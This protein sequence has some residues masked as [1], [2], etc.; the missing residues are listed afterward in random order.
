MPDLQDRLYLE[1]VAGIGH[2]AI[3]LRNEVPSVLRKAGVTPHGNRRR[4]SVPGRREQKVP[5][6]CDARAPGCGRYDLTDHA[7]FLD[8]RAQA[9][10]R[11]VHMAQF[12]LF[13]GGI[14]LT[15]VQLYDIAV[16]SVLGHGA[17]GA[18]IEAEIPVLPLR[19]G[20]DEMKV[21]TIAH[22]MVDENL[23]DF[24]AGQGLAVPDGRNQQEE[25]KHLILGYV[26]KDI[27]IQI[28]G[29]PGFLESG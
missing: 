16:P 25:G 3:L 6:H 10:R 4:A 19:Q 23:E 28:P 12:G 11:I 17:A 9:E 14:E 7:V 22:P 15:L 27:F 26:D 13:Q 24:R 5:L 20:I 29:G 2:I 1:A 18:Q 8:L 21:Q